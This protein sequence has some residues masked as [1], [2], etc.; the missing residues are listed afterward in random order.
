ME[1]GLPTAIQLT[2]AEWLYIQEL[3]YEKIL[4]K[5]RFCHGYGHFARSCKKR[6]EEV[7]IIEKGDQWTQVQ[8]GNSNQ[9]ARKKGK[10]VKFVSG[11]PVAEGPSA[12]HVVVSPKAS[13]NP[14]SILSSSKNILEGCEMEQLD[15]LDIGTDESIALK[16]QADSSFLS[17]GVSPLPKEISPS[18]ANIAW[19]KHG[20]SSGSSED[21]SFEQSKKR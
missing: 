7:T 19:K 11:A 5:C 15:T 9:G 2:V 1:I 21:E 10:E 18:Y 8:K 16:D 12:S 6:I 14:F 3:D 17:P 4:F 13:P 20:V